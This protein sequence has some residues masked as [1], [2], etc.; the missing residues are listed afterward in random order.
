MSTVTRK[1]Q[2]RICK[3]YFLVEFDTNEYMKWKNRQPVVKH[4]S[5]SDEN[6]RDL[7]MHKVC[8]FCMEHQ[9]IPTER[10]NIDDRLF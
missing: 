4:F 3:E 9:T 10:I 8:K 5:K 1:I 6:G 2:C 7:I